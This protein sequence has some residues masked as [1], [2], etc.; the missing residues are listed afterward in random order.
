[1]QT[2][3]EGIAERVPDVVSEHGRVKR[4][5]ASHPSEEGPRV[6]D[7]DGKDEDLP[8]AIRELL[9]S[10]FVDEEGFT[11]EDW[12]HALGGTHVIAEQGGRFPVYVQHN[13]DWSERP[14]IGHVGFQSSAQPIAFRNVTITDLTTE[15]PSGVR[16]VDV[17]EGEGVA[18]VLHHDK[19]GRNMV[20]PKRSVQFEA[21]VRWYKPVAVAVEDQER[22]RIARDKIARTG[23]VRQ[24]EDVLL[25]YVDRSDGRRAS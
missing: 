18:L 1:M 13:W 6:F 20:L 15:L 10:A 5:D 25:E 7:T 17:V 24:V 12:Q 16:Y 11:E 9:G 23:G 3:P 19:L 4:Q 8:S 2:L 14:P 22:R 21:L